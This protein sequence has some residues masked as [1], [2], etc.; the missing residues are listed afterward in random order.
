MRHLIN[1]ILESLDGNTKQFFV[2]LYKVQQTAVKNNKTVQMDIDV[3]K[4]HKPQNPFMKD[5]FLD[6]NILKIVDDQQV[7][8][9]IASRML[10]NDSKYLVDNKAELQLQ[11]NPYFYTLDN[12]TYMAGI[13]IY[14]DKDVFI[15]DF[16]HIIDI[17][18]SL[19][20][21][22]PDIVNKAI[23]NDFISFVK[24]KYQNIV[25][26]SAK[27]IDMDFKNTIVKL[28]FKQMQDNQ[29]LYTLK[30]R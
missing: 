13:N 20:V 7:G 26:L 8:L 12:N 14:D 22:Q 15:K 10:H 1:Y 5:D 24:S 28:G 27:P 6:P 17:E 18:S 23:L 2:D 4:L 16:I 29:A 11:I 3:T 19:I 9:R 21:R 25:G 30:I